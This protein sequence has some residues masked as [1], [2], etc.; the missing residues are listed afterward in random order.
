[1]EKIFG[2]RLQPPPPPEA[3]PVSLGYGN[4]TGFSLFLL[5][6]TNDYTQVIY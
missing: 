2:K 1:M 5:F 3:G 4:R 6:L